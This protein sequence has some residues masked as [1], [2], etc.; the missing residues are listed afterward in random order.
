M[1]PFYNSLRSRVENLLYRF[2]ALFAPLLL[3]LALR[4]F[5]FLLGRHFWVV[6]Y[7][8][9]TRIRAVQKLLKFTAVSV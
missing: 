3:L 5:L 7:T 2:L 8:W 1:H 4:F 9:V 6:I